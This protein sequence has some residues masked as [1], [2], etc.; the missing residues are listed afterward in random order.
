VAANY[1]DSEV[2]FLGEN[3]RKSGERDPDYTGTWK[4]PG[5]PDRWASAWW[6]KRADGSFYLRIIPGRT[7]EQRD[8]GQH[9]ASMHPAGNQ[10][11]MSR[12]HSAPT[13]S[14]PPPGPPGH[15][16]YDGEWNR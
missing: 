8:G 7:K 13:S 10:P 9:P 12:A 3:R 5:T 11:P 16:G 1:P 2:I 15:P 4:V 14:G 6:G